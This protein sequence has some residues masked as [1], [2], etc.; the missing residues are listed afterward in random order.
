MLSCEITRWELAGIYLL[1]QLILGGINLVENF[2]LMQLIF[3]GKNLDG[4]YVL[5]QHIFCT[6]K[7]GGKIYVLIQLLF[8]GKLSADEA[9]SFMEGLFFSTE[10]FGGELSASDTFFWLK[11]D[12]IFLN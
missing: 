11:S 9:R 12:L 8:G 5:I 2:V 10:K 3:G 7:S 1:M 6:E 4:K